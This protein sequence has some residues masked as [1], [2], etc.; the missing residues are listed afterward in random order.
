MWKLANPQELYEC[1]SCGGDYPDSHFKSLAVSP[2][3]CKYCSEG[4]KKEKLFKEYAEYM[5]RIHYNYSEN[6]IRV[7][8][9]YLNM[10]QSLS[11]LLKKYQ[12]DVSNI[13]YSLMYEDIQQLIRVDILYWLH[14]ADRHG[15]K[16]ANEK[17]LLLKIR[18]VVCDWLGEE[19][20]PPEEEYKLRSK[21]RSQLTIKCIKRTALPSM[22][23]MIVLQSLLSVFAD[24]NSN[25]VVY[26]FIPRGTL[27]NALDV[28]MIEDHQLLLQGCVNVA[29]FQYCMNQLSSIHFYGMTEILNES[30]PNWNIPRSITFSRLITSFVLKNVFSLSSSVLLMPLALLKSVY[31]TERQTADAQWIL[32]E[33]EKDIGEYV[34][35]LVYRISHKLYR[36]CKDC[37]IHTMNETKP[38]PP[39]IQLDV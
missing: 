9:D 10:Q 38:L 28:A 25:A 1:S 22:T 23:Q 15:K 13:F 37:A 35:D 4:T 8:L 11:T 19:P 7:L 17:A 18:E 24:P 5:K 33:T 6:E 14:H 20:P 26:K 34:N 27:L 21:D 36:W 3:V 30:C 39:P 32:E 2:L 31:S 12:H 16:S 29:S